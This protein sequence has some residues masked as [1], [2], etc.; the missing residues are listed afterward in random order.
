MPAYTFT[1][2][3]LTVNG[4]TFEGCTV[5]A[6]EI[7]PTPRYICAGS[8]LNGTKLFMSDRINSVVLNDVL[9]HQRTKRERRIHFIYEENIVPALC[10]PMHYPEVLLTTNIGSKVTCRVCLY[11][12]GLL[13][14]K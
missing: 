3:K 10:D 13:A 9:H 8:F 7:I 5:E 11:K 6:I 4:K 14:R 2:V 12:L 1:D